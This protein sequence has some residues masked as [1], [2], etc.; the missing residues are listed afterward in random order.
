[1]THLR[2]Q[3]V[4][5]FSKRVLKPNE[6]NLKKWRDRRCILRPSQPLQFSS[7]CLYRVRSSKKDSKKFVSCCYYKRVPKQWHFF[8][9]RTIAPFGISQADSQNTLL[10]D[11]IA[12]IRRDLK[13]PEK[14]CGQLSF[15]HWRVWVAENDEKIGASVPRSTECEIGI[16]A[17]GMPN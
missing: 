3:E 5:L 17:F 4:A 6:R 13:R 12:E 7:F 16:G 1:M 2:C 15:E 11:C 8:L 10:E 9:L 14:F